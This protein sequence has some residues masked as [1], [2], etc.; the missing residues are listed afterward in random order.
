MSTESPVNTSSPGLR[1]SLDIR[2]MI[3]DSVSDTGIKGKNCQES[4]VSMNGDPVRTYAST[5]IKSDL[6]KIGDKY[7]KKKVHTSSK[8]IVGHFLKN[9]KQRKARKKEEIEPGIGTE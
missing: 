3:S 5:I 1:P 8:K 4:K 7:I 9:R 2:Y 6:K